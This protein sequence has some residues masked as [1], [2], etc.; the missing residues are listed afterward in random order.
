MSNV[1]ARVDDANVPAFV[2]GE[3][4]AQGL[5]E[6]SK[7]IRPP[8]LKIIQKM[9]REPFDKFDEGTVLVVPSVQIIKTPFLFTPLFFFSEWCIWN[10][11][12]MMGQLPVIRDRSFDPGSKIA[13]MSAVKET[14]TFP[15]P[16][17]P[18][19]NCVVSGHLNFLFMIHGDTPIQN[20]PV[21][22]TFVR[23]EYGTGQTLLTLINQR[24]QYSIYANIFEANVGDHTGPLGKWK[25]F[26]ITF[27]EK[28][29]TFV[30]DEAA[31]NIYAE[32]H[33]SFKKAHASFLIQTDFDDKSVVEEASATPAD[34]SDF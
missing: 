4:K 12:Q 17:K 1:P 7:Y 10:P 6:I 16:E 14:R 3:E 18:E 5:E 2:R 11:I 28:T 26:D 21:L 25:G 30:E 32:V 19:F 22:Q 31:F 20:I 33:K 29:S 23:G 27:P 24:Q 34:S 9:A 13:Q 8:R 15:C